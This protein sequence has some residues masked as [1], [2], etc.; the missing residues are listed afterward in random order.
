MK[1]LFMLFR[2]LAQNLK[3]FRY[4]YVSTWIRQ[5]F[6]TVC[7]VRLFMSLNSNVHHQQFQGKSN[8][9]T[10]VKI[11][12]ANIMKQLPNSSIDYVDILDVWDAQYLCEQRHNHASAAAMILRLKTIKTQRWRKSLSGCSYSSK[13]EEKRQ[14]KKKHLS[15]A[16]I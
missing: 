5:L 8:K 9:K 6:K 2:F 3:C 12:T 4:C 14:N 1:Y 11:I 13:G 16:G 15:C 10:H 7:L